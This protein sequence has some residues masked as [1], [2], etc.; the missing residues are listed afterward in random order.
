[1]AFELLDTLTNSQRVFTPIEKGK[2]K[3]YVCGVT[4][5]DMSHIGH[6]RA[7]IVW[8]TLRRYLTYLGYEVT[9][10]QNYT[11]ID[12]KIIAKANTAG[13]SIDE[14]TKKYIAE[15]EQDMVSLNILPPTINPKATE[16]IPQMLHMV[17]ELETTG[18]AYDSDGDV[19]FDVGS[20]S[21]YLKLSKRKMDNAMQGEEG[22][23]K[24]KNHADFSLWKKSKP[25]EPYWESKWGNGRPG[26]HLECS[27]MIKAT[28]G[29]TIDIHCGGA[30][31][32]FP[33]H[34]NEIAQSESLTHRPLANFWLHNGFVNIDNEKMSKSL[35][36]F[37]TIREIVTKY[38]PMALRFFVLSSHYRTPLDFS[39]D[40][41]DGAWNGL[42]TLARGLESLSNEPLNEF[43]EKEV[44]AEILFF[45]KTLRD[46]IEAAI[47]KDFNTPAGIAV[48]FKSIDE[49]KKLIRK[50]P[51][52]G[53]YYRYFIEQIL[54]S[55]LGIDMDKVM[56]DL[57]KP[58]LVYENETYTDEIDIA[59]LGRLM[60]K[61]NK[62]YAMADK[63][64][65]ELQNKYNITMEDAKDFIRWFKN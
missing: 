47:S 36:N 5:Y 40:A 54:N 64:R 52:G 55:V 44:P 43:I 26:W 41:L 1:M 23:V 51:D 32:V 14:V 56:A 17:E 8:D 12:D 31:L 25:N 13:I 19:L 20:F 60:A 61:L 24:K 59:V 27:A 16:Y 37:I 29:E 11:D 65:D 39:Y 6:A 53:K 28:L 33:H 38:N 49:A 15:F 30:D 45:R 34:E 3:M 21:D 62:D 42:K 58:H 9:Y 63:L 35:G 50:N 48:I 57:P 2:V 22:L 7:Y 46:S 4:V 18:H 10:V